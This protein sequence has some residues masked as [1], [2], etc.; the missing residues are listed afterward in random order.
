M[1]KPCQLNVTNVPL[2]LCVNKLIF[3]QSL[4]SICCLLKDSS[5]NQANAN[6]DSFRY[7]NVVD[8]IVALRTASSTITSSSVIVRM[9]VRTSMRLRQG[10]SCFPKQM[11]RTWTSKDS[12]DGQY[13]QYLNII[14]SLWIGAKHTVRNHHFCPKIQLWFP[15]K[16]VNFLGEKLVKMLWVWTFLLLT[17]LSWEKLSKKFWAKNSWKCWGFLS[18]L[19]FW[20]KIWLFE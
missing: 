12:W 8:E 14:F 4:L 10:I 19:N 2:D 18:K 17:T 5:C 1:R 7:Q 3:I 20:T 11:F 9:R 16:I 6:A 15:V 13:Q